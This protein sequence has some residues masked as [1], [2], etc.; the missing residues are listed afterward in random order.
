MKRQFNLWM[1]RQ[2]GDAAGSERGADIPMARHLQ[3]SLWFAALLAL[4]AV[5]PRARGRVVEAR[6]QGAGACR[7]PG[8]QERHRRPGRV[9][10]GLHGLHGLHG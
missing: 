9:S 2:A 7:R 5:G 6:R 10:E 3:A 4:A 8:P 1:R